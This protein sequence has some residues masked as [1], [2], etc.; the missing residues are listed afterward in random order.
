MITNARC[1]FDGVNE[2]STYVIKTVV[3]YS[4]LELH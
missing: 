3:Y 4:L 2:D 1:H